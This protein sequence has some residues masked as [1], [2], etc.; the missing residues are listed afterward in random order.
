MNGG[1]GGWMEEQDPEE[2]EGGGSQGR[3]QFLVKQ[4]QSQHDSQK[5]LWSVYLHVRIFL[6][7]SQEC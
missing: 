5:G 1:E 3:E 4:A 2:A 7:L 6:I